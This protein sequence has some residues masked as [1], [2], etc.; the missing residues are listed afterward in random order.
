EYDYEMQIEDFQVQTNKGILV[1]GDEAG[2]GFNLAPRTNFKNIAVARL[3]LPNGELGPT[4]FFAHGKAGEA[5]INSPFRKILEQN[6]TASEKEL[7]AGLKSSGVEKLADALAA[8]KKEE[9]ETEGGAAKSKGGKTVQL[10]QRETHE[11]L[12][13]LV[14]GI[15]NIKQDLGKESDPF[16][17]AF[18]PIWKLQSGDAKETKRPRREFF[19]PNDTKNPIYTAEFK[20]D[21]N[22][23]ARDWNPDEHSLVKSD[24]TNEEDAMQNKGGSS[25]SFD[26]DGIL[27][28]DVKGG[29]ATGDL[30]LYAA[31]GHEIIPSFW[32]DPGLS[33]SYDSDGKKK[34]HAFRKAIKDAVDAMNG[35]KNK[36]Y[37]NVAVLLDPENKPI[38]ETEAGGN[39]MFLIDQ[40]QV[41][42]KAS[43]AVLGGKKIV[44]RESE[45]QGRL[46]FY[47][48][49]LTEGAWGGNLYPDTYA[50]S[51]FTLQPS[52][53]KKG[54][55]DMVLKDG[56]KAKI[57]K[58]ALMTIDGQVS[59]E[60]ASLFS[61]VE[62]RRVSITQREPIM[63]E[64]GEVIVDTA[65]PK[66]S[67]Q[68][69]IREQGVFESGIAKYSTE[70]Y[71]PGEMDQILET[72]KTGKRT[73]SPTLYGLWEAS[74]DYTDPQKMGD[75][76]KAKISV[77][78]T[79]TLAGAGKGE[80]DVVVEKGTGPRLADM[81]VRPTG[82]GVEVRDERD[83]FWSF[84][85]PELRGSSSDDPAE[86]MKQAKQFVA[87]LVKGGEA[88]ASSARKMSQALVASLGGEG[89][90]N[91]EEEVGLLAQGADPQK[92]V[93]TKGEP[94]TNS[95]W[96]RG[97]KIEQ[98]GGRTLVAGGDLVFDFGA[99][100][101][102]GK[103]VYTTTLH[104]QLLI[105]GSTYDLHPSAEDKGIPRRV[106]IEDPKT[107]TIMYGL[108]RIYRDTTDTSFQIAQD[109]Y[110]IRSLEIEQDPLAKAEWVNAVADALTPDTEYMPRGIYIDEQGQPRP[111]GS[112]GFGMD[113]TS[114]QNIGAEFENFE[115]EGQAD[116]LVDRSLLSTNEAMTVERLLGEMEIRDYKGVVERVA[117]YLSEYAAEKGEIRSKRGPTSQGEHDRLVELR[118]QGV[119]YREAMAI[120]AEEEASE[121]SLVDL[122]PEGLSQGRKDA[123]RKIFTELENDENF[124]D[125]IK[126]AHGLTSTRNY[127]KEI[128]PTVL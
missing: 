10:L 61:V 82:T 33:Q 122:I 115:N 69:E 87:G 16:H 34:Y 5:E 53:D 86:Q 127:W 101:P 91:N 31:D 20:V 62:I 11:G 22:Y 59:V 93:G 14:A 19:S 38:G 75:D 36:N 84:V 97:D 37:E 72:R 94:L 57:T 49:P 108:Q 52:K 103:K 92:E 2:Y 56:V 71:T 46:S 24:L 44:T 85:P 83:H 15:D 60:D 25:L 21:E 102:D 77:D 100:G 73:I 8:K 125:G 120:I 39:K 114:Y 41:D 51:R 54:G 79:A 55:F 9:A 76:V 118:N 32:V 43:V 106:L 30:V 3:E 23:A 40:G 123:L 109:L 96:V 42:Q 45:G 81:R 35:K 27:R 65:K 67:I 80:V 78:R 98:E 119:P 88:V 105:P 58:G 110:G 12:L 26:K 63:N 74:K 70:I 6:I 126:K 124:E 117:K 121:V 47:A 68:T 111:F 13:S 48:N 50:K 7:L 90:D 89:G 66:K 99:M 18:I 95:G 107:G 29:H 1:Y 116:A 17:T 64:V 112:E 104:P 4:Q 28:F 128:D 113:V